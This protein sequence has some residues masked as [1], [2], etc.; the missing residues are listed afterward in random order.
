MR[1]KAAAGN[2]SPSKPVVVCL[3]DS[4]TVCGGE[5]GRYTDWLAQWLT[6]AEIINQGVGGDTLAGGRARLQRDVLAWHPQV[7]VIELDANDF[8]SRARSLDDLQA[9]LDDMVVRCRQAGAEVVIASCFGERNYAQEPR[10]EFGPERFDYA[11]AFAEMERRVAAKHRCFYVPAL[12]V[13]IKPNGRAPYWADS[14]H[15]NKAGN[16]F[17]ARRIFA[18]VQKALKPK[19]KHSYLTKN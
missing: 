4:L 3:G 7:V 15:P 16:K 13:D 19:R 2:T 8:W 6:Q 17:V 5:G 12:Q 14:R 9:D 1:D 11:R 18:E 10:A